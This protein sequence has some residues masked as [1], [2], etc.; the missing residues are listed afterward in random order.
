MDGNRPFNVIYMRMLLALIADQLK[1]SINPFKKSSIVK[2]PVCL[3]PLAG[4]QAELKLGCTQ[5]ARK[6]GRYGKAGFSS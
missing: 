3:T 2:S 6:L 4:A 5:A 1:F